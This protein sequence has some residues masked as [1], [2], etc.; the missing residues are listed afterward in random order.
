MKI[1]WN[2]FQFWERGTERERERARVG[3]E[4]KREKI[5]TIKSSDRKIKPM[6]NFRP[7]HS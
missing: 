5:T 6:P 2:L 7:N 1:G 3:S 4:K